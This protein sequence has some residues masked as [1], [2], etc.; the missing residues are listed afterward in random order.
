MSEYPIFLKVEVVQARRRRNETK[1][2]G[3][4]DKVLVPSDI[5]TIIDSNGMLKSG[6]GWRAPYRSAIL[7]LISRLSDDY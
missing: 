5:L 3:T 1:R 2:Y 7:P 6:R 4:Q